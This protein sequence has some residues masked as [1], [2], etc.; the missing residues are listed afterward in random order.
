[1]NNLLY[2][3]KYLVCWIAVSQIVSLGSGEQKPRA[4]KKPMDEVPCNVKVEQVRELGPLQFDKAIRGRDGGFSA[5]FQDRSVW[6]FGDTILHI[7]GVDG[8]NWRT[9]TC[10]LTQDFDAR[11]GIEKLEDPVDAK[12]A[13]KLFL[14]YT[15]AE[16]TYNKINDANTLADQD[17][18]KWAIWPGPLLVHP[19]SDTAYLFYG[20]ILARHGM[21]NFDWVGNSLAT[22]AGVNQPVIRPHVGSDPNEPTLLFPKGDAIVGSGAFVAGDWI[23]AYGC[24]SKKFSWPC[25]LGRVKFS[26]ALQRDAWEFYAGNNRWSKN[27]NDAIPVMDA[28]PMLSVH[29]NEYLGKYLAVYSRQLINE[30]AIRTADRPEG[31]WSAAQVVHTCMIPTEGKTWTYSGLTHSEFSRD[32]G[33]VEYITYYRETGFLQGEI[34][35]VE[36]TYSK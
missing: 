13:P 21:F 5:R 33:R 9:S 23:Y 12:G 30:I 28:A 8:K 19:K 16:L 20:K 7:K 10:C 3:H 36:I 1:M 26:D 34:R 31:P 18:S 35:L 2:L 32:K 4:A 11:N 17:R 25:I 29:W 27:G 14:P 15:P 22:W 24:E 6:V